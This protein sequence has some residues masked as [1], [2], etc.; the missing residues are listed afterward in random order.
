MA[1]ALLFGFVTPFVSRGRP[2]DGLPRTEMWA[3]L[4]LFVA[5][6]VFFAGNNYG[7]LQ[8]NTG[9]RYMAPGIPFL[10]V[11]AA[12]VLLR[13]PRLLL[14]A[15]AIVSVVI[16][17]SASMHR[18]VWHPTGV[19]GPVI[20]VLTGGF[21]LPALTTLSRMQMFSSIVERGV[22]PLPLMVL[23]AVII[24]LIWRPANSP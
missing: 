4:L 24:F 2:D 11:P 1:P 6:W 9:V 23:A 15:V 18:E 17:W 21:E 20:S 3:C 13:L 12:I 19:F 5:L 10:F 22:S 8:W 7:N 16:N 14:G